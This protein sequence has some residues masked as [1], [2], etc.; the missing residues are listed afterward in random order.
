MSAHPHQ[1]TAWGMKSV[2]PPPKKKATEHTE[3][4]SGTAKHPP[5]PVCTIMAQQSQSTTPAA[6]QGMINGLFIRAN[7]TLI[8]LKLHAKCSG[9]LGT[10]LGIKRKFTKQWDASRQQPTPQFSSSNMWF[11][12]MGKHSLNFIQ[13]LEKQETP[14]Q[15]RKHLQTSSR[16]QGTDK[17]EERDPSLSKTHAHGKAFFFLQQQPEEGL[18]KANFMGNQQVKT[19]KASRLTGQSRRNIILSTA[20]S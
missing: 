11:G 10:V 15:P 8:T 5:S 19:N 17:A 12:Y 1:Y 7:W 3:G 4:C 20:D 2:R 9:H 6:P 13:F 16:G 18:E 14:E